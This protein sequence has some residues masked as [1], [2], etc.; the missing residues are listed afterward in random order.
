M[1]NCLA[2]YVFFD[3]FYASVMDEP[4]ESRIDGRTD[5]LSDHDEMEMD[6]NHEIM[7]EFLLH[8]PSIC[9]LCY[10]KE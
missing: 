2:K 6:Q 9:L 1:I 5:G 4:R 7:F 10:L 8:R 3:D